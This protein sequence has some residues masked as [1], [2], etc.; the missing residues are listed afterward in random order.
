MGNFEIS[1]YVVGVIVFTMLVL[2]TYTIMGNVFDPNKDGAFLNNTE[3]S[4]YNK[5]FN[6]QAQLEADISALKGNV[7][8]ATPGDDSGLLSSINS[9]IKTA[10]SGVKFMLSSFSVMDDSYNGL[11]SI[12]G[13]PNWVSSLISTLMT[14]LILF[15]IY[16]LIFRSPTV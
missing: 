12:F 9:L 13:L 6:K 10:F 3:Y 5:V 7:S 1:D 14:A 8:G 2:G 4:D 16:K 15:A 11:S